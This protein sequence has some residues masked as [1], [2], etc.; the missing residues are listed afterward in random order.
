MTTFFLKGH[1]IM[2]QIQSTWFPLIDRN[3]QSLYRAF[4]ASASDFVPARQRIYCS[5]KM[6]SHLVLP[7]CAKKEQRRKRN[8]LACAVMCP[9]RLRGRRRQ[10]ER[11]TAC[12]SHRGRDLRR[13]QNR[14]RNP[15]T[16]PRR[17]AIPGGD[18]KKEAAW[19]PEA[20]VVAIESL[21]PV[22]D[23]KGQSVRSGHVRKDDQR[24]S[25]YR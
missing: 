23:T 19:Q 5:P 3:P 14:R 22:S 9:C 21:N 8:I 4:K 6:P 10:C 18:F 13:R 20:V 24:E 11:C 12:T 17:Q 25:A 1:R 16:S 7:S 2:V 15:N